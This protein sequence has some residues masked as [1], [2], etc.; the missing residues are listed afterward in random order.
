[1]V[2]SNYLT[3]IRSCPLKLSAQNISHSDSS[4]PHQ[5][6]VLTE[7][8]SLPH[9]LCKITPRRGTLPYKPLGSQ[10]GVIG[11]SRSKMQEHAPLPGRGSCH[12]GCHFNT[13]T[14]TTT[15][16]DALSR[17]NQLRHP[18]LFR[19]KLGSLL[20]IVNVD[21]LL[22]PFPSPFLLSYLLNLLQ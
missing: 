2:I 13:L 9:E 4:N 22:N 3:H 11:A 8:F 12:P 20:C 7:Q 14:L 16:S 1:M 5:T 21:R 15:F 18:R 6:L 17:L 19:A 10:Q